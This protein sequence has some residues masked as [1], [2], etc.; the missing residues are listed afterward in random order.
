MQASTSSKKWEK[1]KES[2]YKSK[3]AG[4]STR[5]PLKTFLEDDHELAKNNCGVWRKWFEFPFE[6]ESQEEA[7]SHIVTD[8]LTYLNDFCEGRTKEVGFS[9]ASGYLGIMSERKA[10]LIPIGRDA[11]SN[12][13]PKE[14]N[15]VVFGNWDKE[16]FLTSLSFSEDDED[17]LSLIVLGQSNGKFAV[18]DFE[19]M[20]EVIRFA[21]KKHE[22]NSIRFVKLFGESKSS[23]FV[24]SADVKGVISLAQVQSTFFGM[25]VTKDEVIS[26][27]E[28]GGVTSLSVL[29][30]SVQKTMREAVRNSLKKKSHL[31]INKRSSEEQE[32]FLEEGKPFK[33]RYL[34]FG[35][36]N[37][38]VI[39]KVVPSFQVLF[40]FE[41][42]SFF[43]TDLAPV[44]AWGLCETHQKPETSSQEAEVHSCLGIFW[45]RFGFLFDLVE[46]IKCLVGLTPYSIAAVVP[47]FCALPLSCEFLF[48]HFYSADSLVT[49]VEHSQQAGVRESFY[50]FFLSP[51][52]FYPLSPSQS[53]ISREPIIFPPG[54]KANLRD[55]S[56]F[57]FQKKPLRNAS[58]EDQASAQKV[59]PFLTHIE[60]FECS[61]HNVARS[62]SKRG[63]GFT[64]KEVRMGQKYFPPY[65][66]IPVQ[67]TQEKAYSL[68]KSLT[69]DKESFSFYFF[70]PEK[71]IWRKT[72][73]SLKEF[74]LLL[75]RK[76]KWETLFRLISQ[77]RQEPSDL[78]FG[79]KEEARRLALAFLHS[80]AF[81]D[82]LKERN[83]TE[84]HPESGFA[85]SKES[86]NNQ[87]NP[88][89]PISERPSSKEKEPMMDS[90]EKSQTSSNMELLI[91][92][93]VSIDDFE[94]LLREIMDRVKETPSLFQLFFKALCPFVLCGK[95]KRVPS[96]D[97]CL[98]L[99]QGL[100]KTH[101]RKRAVQTLKAFFFFGDFAQI[102]RGLVFQEL[103]NWKLY[104]SHAFLMGKY[105]GD[106][107]TSLHKAFSFGVHMNTQSLPFS[108]EFQF[109][110]SQVAKGLSG[111]VPL[112]EKTR[113]ELIFFISL[114]NHLKEFL[115]K[116][117][118]KTL[119]V[120]LL[121]TSPENTSILLKNQK[122][123]LDHLS[124]GNRGSL[125][126]GVLPALA[127]CV[128]NCMK[129]AQ[130]RKCQMVASGSES[131][132]F[133]WALWFLRLLKR[134]SYMEFSEALEKSLHVLLENIEEF[135][136]A[137]T[138]V[139][140]L[141]PKEALPWS[142]LFNQK[143]ALLWKEAVL[144]G[145]LR[146]I[147]KSSRK[148]E[149]ERLLGLFQNKKE[150]LL[151]L[152]SLQGVLKQTEQ[153]NES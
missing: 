114:P 64:E 3:K 29:P 84:T 60:P 141:D 24:L 44:L 118:P 127:I 26:Q 34:A 143:R 25:K 94:F 72:V 110:L 100:F 17:F 71:E 107:M 105:E 47:S 38:I 12:E 52:N 98:L 144:I 138:P 93:L 36:H 57:C 62:P 53:S 50:F 15:N 137:E 117:K 79:R 1:V 41:R 65:L 103:F 136:E 70:S 89:E 140:F 74:L 40:V 46:Q 6:K 97:C 20:K 73:L 19:K 111:S 124:P 132:E 61:V 99:I 109:A 139:E 43:K 8:K 149:R 13:G 102:E 153:N 33:H 90:N 85:P 22:G 122:A 96:A 134:T 9:S 150:F 133:Q 68:I 108:E 59:W 48:A 116:E 63:T 115:G 58:K 130:V 82:A 23:F 51:K 31:Q 14:R 152:G 42:P 95:I 119:E 30:L 148:E 76:R 80:S 123:F 39:A 131:A 125:K 5:N 87:L 129:E 4:Q 104:S 145:V 49:L 56:H 88:N 92:F 45:D 69:I 37:C 28:Y 66:M 7:E 146:T 11:R 91:D 86:Q 83:P 113:K 121:L 32:E 81:R 21:P 67:D 27:G 35:T 78:L 101:P 2:F 135:L 142:S 147:I 77:S 16:A 126:M 151:D 128:L 120:L 55:F 10:H 54:I 75:E 112:D 106:F 18:F